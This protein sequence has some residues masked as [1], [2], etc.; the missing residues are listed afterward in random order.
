MIALRINDYCHSCPDF[1]AEVETLRHGGD[2][3]TFVSCSHATKC[4]RIKRHL[5][6]SI[7]ETGTDEVHRK[8]YDTCHTCKYWHDN[9]GCRG[10]PCSA[11]SNTT[12]QGLAGTRVCRCTQ[13]RYDYPCP[14]YEEA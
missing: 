10:V 4:E 3:H 7:K 14:Y 6:K 2:C 11:C 13:I 8:G 9:R 12:K 1:D 5:E